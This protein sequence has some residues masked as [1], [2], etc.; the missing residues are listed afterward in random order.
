[1]YAAGSERRRMQCISLRTIV[2]V[3]EFL[4]K[5]RKQRTTHAHGLRVWP[6]AHSTRTRR[7]CRCNEQVRIFVRASVFIRVHRF[8][9]LDHI[10]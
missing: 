9:R 4:L 10:I 5:Y 2:C 8:V 6:H 1:M 3:V 7:L